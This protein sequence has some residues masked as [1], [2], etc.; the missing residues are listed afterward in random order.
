MGQLEVNWGDVYVDV[1]QFSIIICDG[2]AVVFDCRVTK[3]KTVGVEG[4]E[5]DV[6]VDKG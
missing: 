5:C 6:V 3:E 2:D 1:F 4:G